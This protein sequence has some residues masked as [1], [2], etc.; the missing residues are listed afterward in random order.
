MVAGSTPRR[1][2][3][4]LPHRNDPV[5]RGHGPDT[6]PPESLFQTIPS[7][8]TMEGAFESLT[9]IMSKTTKIANRDVPI[10]PGELITVS[11]SGG[12]A[13]ESEAGAWEYWTAFNNRGRI[14]ARCLQG[15]DP[16]ERFRRMEGEK[17]YEDSWK[18]AATAKGIRPA[19]QAEVIKWLKS[20]HEDALFA[21]FCQVGGRTMSVV[22]AADDFRF[23]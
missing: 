5:D 19:T 21:E 13:G 20:H 16:G 22:R 17:G 1:D 4:R 8:V 2:H 10:E 12:R 23:E 6:R 7:S 14:T 11:F 15:S 18:V 3:V 9:L